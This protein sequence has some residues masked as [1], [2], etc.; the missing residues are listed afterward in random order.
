[1]E[2][3][4]HSLSRLIALCETRLLPNNVS[5]QDK[6]K[7]YALYKQSMYGDCD[8]PV[9][10]NDFKNVDELERHSAWKSLKGKSKY[11]AMEEYTDLMKNIAS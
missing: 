5:Y 4:D 11:E 6:V 10:R 2:V 3:K 8:V 9:P 1:M 7:M